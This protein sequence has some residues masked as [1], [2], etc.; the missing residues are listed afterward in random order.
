MKN[1]DKEVKDYLDTLE[2]VKK[3]KRD[4]REAKALL[5]TAI[6]DTGRFDMLEIKRDAIK[7][8]R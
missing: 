6:I 3:A 5:M 4:A 2:T 8:Y 1:I 7:Y